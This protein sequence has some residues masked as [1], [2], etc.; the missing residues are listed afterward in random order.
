MLVVV[1]TEG[2]TFKLFASEQTARQEADLRSKRW[3]GYA[4]R[5]DMHIEEDQ[6][7]DQDNWILRKKD[8]GY[9]SGSRG[10]SVLVAICTGRT[11]LPTPHLPKQRQGCHRSIQ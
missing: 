2:A 11:F 3:G 10:L 7:I 8:P 6:G 4:G 9:V 1:E 5:P